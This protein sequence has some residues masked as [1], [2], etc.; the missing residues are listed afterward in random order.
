MKVRY[1]AVG[2]SVQFEVCVMSQH[3][4]DCP[5]GRNGRYLDMGYSPGARAGMANQYHL[6]SR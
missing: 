3:R 4:S 6:V 2:V 5:K 1:H